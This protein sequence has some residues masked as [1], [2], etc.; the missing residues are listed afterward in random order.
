MDDLSAPTGR[1]PE[2]AAM[3][4]ADGSDPMAV[5][6]GGTGYIG[7]R[8]VPRLIAAGY[9]VRVFARDLSRISAFSWGSGVE[10]VAGDA[11]DPG[12]VE[13]AVEGADVL[14]Y[15]VH[16]MSAG[17]GF[18]QTDRSAADTVATAAAA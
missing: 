18:E 16:S 1:E 8:L 6:F 7:G 3:P 15:L 2:L 10:G 14:Y 17:K 13:R 12:A 5:V 11:T 4:R 9:R